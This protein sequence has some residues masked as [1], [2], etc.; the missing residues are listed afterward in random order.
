MRQK[1]YI[2]IKKIK[3]SSNKCKTT[4]DIIKKLSN[5]QQ[6]QTDIHELM[7]DTKHLKDQQ[8]TTDA[9]NKHFSSIID[10]ISI[11]NINNKTDKENFLTFHHYLEQS[12]SY[13]LPSLVIKTFSTKEIAPIIKTLKKKIH[14]VIARSLLKY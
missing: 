13:P 3:K 7:T 5:S 6:P 8:D 10:K 12:Y 9:F 4:W 11:N 2:I 1:V 14:V